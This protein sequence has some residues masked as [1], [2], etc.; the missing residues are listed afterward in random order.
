MK[1]KKQNQDTVGITEIYT[2]DNP[3]PTRDEPEKKPYIVFV[4][5]YNDDNDDNLDYLRWTTGLSFL[6]TIDKKNKKLI[7]T[8]T[9]NGKVKAAINAFLTATIKY[10]SELNRDVRRAL[11]AYVKPINKSLQRKQPQTSL[12][13]TGKRTSQ[14]EN[15]TEPQHITLNITHEVAK[16]NNPEKKY[17]HKSNRWG[18]SINEQESF[19]S[20]CFQLL[21]S[22]RHP[23]KCRI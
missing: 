19:N 9:G 21:L 17:I 8:I 7:L 23:S 22:E 12:P 2:S 5:P 20:Y 3:H 10:P 4:L 16:I 13:L 18:R 1:V 6:G 11:N 15:V 14:F